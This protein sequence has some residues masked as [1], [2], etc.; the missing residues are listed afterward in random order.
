[1]SGFDFNREQRQLINPKI[2]VICINKNGEKYI[3]DT[4][5]SVLQQDYDDFEF[6]VSDGGSTDR[7]LEIIGKYKFIKLLPGQD[8]SRIE[9]LLRAV[10]AARGRYVMVTTST[11]GYLSRNWFKSASFALDNESQVSLVF[12]ASACMSEVG[13]L[14]SIS[15]PRFFSFNNVP[16]K[17]KWTAMWLKH[18]LSLAYF[19]ELNYCVRI[20]VFRNLIGPS[21]QF[22]ELNQIDPILRF[23]FEFNRFGYLPKYISTLA[24]FG[25]THINQEQFSERHQS[26]VSNYNKAWK[27]YRKGVI[28]GKY[29]HVLRDG[30][31]IEVIDSKYSLFK[32]MMLTLPRIPSIISVLRRGLNKI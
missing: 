26:Y 9:G 8:S 17:E 15:Y 2:S 21:T 5:L 29:A 31:G 20:D 28:S 19:P 22:S 10:A 12:G 32:R 30:N 3:E 16:S 18:G 6:I 25:R 14:G 13:A 7:S 24:N 27:K 23:H 4:I 1:M 11:D